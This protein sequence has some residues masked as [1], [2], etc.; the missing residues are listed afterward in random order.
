M[1]MVRPA[2]RQPPACYISSSVYDKRLPLPQHTCEPGD[3]RPSAVTV[4]ERHD[5][6]RQRSPA[7]RTKQPQRD[8]RDTTRLRRKPHSRSSYKR[9]TAQR[10][11]RCRWRSRARHAA[12]VLRRSTPF[13]DR[14][15]AHCYS[16]TIRSERAVNCG[17]ADSDIQR[18]MVAGVAASVCR[19]RCH[20]ARWRSYQQN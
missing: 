1:F 9:H 5:A 7:F 15:Q 18:N 20:G 4:E 3:M 17:A 10:A 14:E 13:R 6:A 19:R 8:S 2:R 16:Q 11:P 12:T